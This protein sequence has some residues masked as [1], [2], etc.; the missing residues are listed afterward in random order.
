MDKL[1]FLR[2]RALTLAPH[3]GT[4]ALTQASDYAQFY[5]WHPKIICMLP[6]PPA[7]TAL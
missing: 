7:H 1:F 2:G 6:N 3:A 4:N 5:K